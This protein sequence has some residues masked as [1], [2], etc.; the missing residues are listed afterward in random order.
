MQYSDNF[1][2]YIEK[3]EE[4]LSAGMDPARVANFLLK[5]GGYRTD[6]REA[7]EGPSHKQHMFEDGMEVFSPRELNEQY[8]LSWD[9]RNKGVWCLSRDTEWESRKGDRPIIP[10]LNRHE[11]GR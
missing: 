6:G 2:G 9:Q 1:Q 8:D 7:L 10:N 11:E 3:A 4:F 5:V